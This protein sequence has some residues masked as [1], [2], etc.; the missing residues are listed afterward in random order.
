MIAL[1]SWQ[2]TKFQTKLD[3]D[4]QNFPDKNEYRDKTT[5]LANSAQN[6]WIF[7]SSPAD[8]FNHSLMNFASSIL[9]Q[10]PNLNPKEKL[11]NVR[12]YGNKV[13]KKTN[14]SIRKITQ[15]FA[16]QVIKV[17]QNFADQFEE[18]LYQNGCLNGGSVKF[19]ACIK[20]KCQVS[21]LT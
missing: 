13:K 11:V 10:R 21:P 4:N 18:C 5:L 15:I 9:L 3:V 17:T 19:L 8:Q 1:Y 2:L 12:N 7:K 20:E 6:V 14:T 16:F